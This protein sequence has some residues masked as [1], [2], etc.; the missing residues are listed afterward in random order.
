MMNQKIGHLESSDTFGVRAAIDTTDLITAMDGDLIREK[1]ADVLFPGQEFLLNVKRAFPWSKPG[2]GVVEYEVV[3][4]EE[5]KDTRILYAQLNPDGKSKFPDSIMVNSS[6]LGRVERDLFFRGIRAICLAESKMTLSTFPL[7][8]RM[9]WVRELLDPD[10]VWKLLGSRLG[11]TLNV[12]ILSIDEEPKVLGY[13]FGKRCTLM[14]RLRGRD[15]EGK[16]VEVPVIG[17]IH[18]D[19][20]GRVIFDNLKQ[21]WNWQ[22][23]APGTRPHLVPSPLCYVPEYRIYFQEAGCGSTLFEVKEGPFR[24]DI[25]TRTGAILSSFHGSGLIGNGSYSPEDELTLLGK[26]IGYLQTICPEL[27]ELSNDLLARIHIKAESPEVSS[28]KPVIT[29]RDFFDKQVITCED[30]LLLIDLDTAA[31]ADPAID[32][33]N[34]VSHIFLRAIQRGA[35]RS[36]MDQESNL[37]VSS[38]HAHNPGVGSER[39]AFYTA[40][41]LFRLACLYAY[42]PRWKSLCHN[43][44]EECRQRLSRI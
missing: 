21:L 5:G 44:L 31:M 19:E 26:W 11:R 20:R 40:T 38:Y 32:V 28:Y 42:R 7:D 15:E 43:L 2:G 35:S 25:L 13:R 12:E 9:P 18:F 22:T 6:P 39:I 14:Y 30:G 27:S 33:G 37:F 36:I 3:V 17:K 24:R 34:F 23:E 41:S 16:H 1:L 8:Y 4:G 10:R 29:H